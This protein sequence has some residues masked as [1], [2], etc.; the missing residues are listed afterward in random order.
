MAKPAE[1]DGM[2]IKELRELKVRI[3]IAIVEREKSERLGLRQKMMQLAA[4]A[5]LTLDEI[6]GGKS[7]KGSRSPVAVKYRNPDDSS[8]TWTGR[9]RRP[10]WLAEKLANRGASIEDFTV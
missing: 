2:S 4:D 7:G 3:D 5:G 8:Q 10:V 6:L 1:L 9:G